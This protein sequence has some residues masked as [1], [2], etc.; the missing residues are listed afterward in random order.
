MVNFS[1]RRCDLIESS[2]TGVQRYMGL[3]LTLREK[4][5]QL[6]PPCLL[7]RDGRKLN[8]GHF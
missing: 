2:F 6:L 1:G 8:K 3:G 4:P 5:Q 7:F